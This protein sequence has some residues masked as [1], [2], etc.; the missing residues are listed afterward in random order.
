MTELRNA[1]LVLKGSDLTQ[2][3][4]TEV[5]YTD[6]NR[7]TMTWYNINLRTLLGDMYEQYDYFNLCLNTIATGSAGSLSAEKNNLNLYVRMSGLPWSN[8][9]YNIKNK[10]NTQYNVMATFF[11][12]PNN[13]VSQYY[14]GNN[15][16]TFAKNQDNCNIT[17]DFIK[18]SDDAVPNLDNSFPPTIFI[19]DIIG[20]P[21]TS[22]LSEN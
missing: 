20:I 22:Y 4:Y 11:F 17:I 9:T 7:T 13:A 8:Q 12:N 2:N 6:A 3:Q 15:F 1:S 14:Y 5:G 18:I 19:F 10:C 16:A 21:K